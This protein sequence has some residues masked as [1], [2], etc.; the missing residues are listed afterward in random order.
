MRLA[1]SL[2][3]STVRLTTHFLALA[4]RQYDIRVFAL[5]W[6]F[7]L[8]IALLLLTAAL[9]ISLPLV[10]LLCTRR[11]QTAT[12]ILQIF[13]KE[14]IWRRLDDDFDNEDGERESLLSGS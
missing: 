12:D 9:A 1:A 8:V 3:V 6:I 7:A 11:Y 5:Q 13:G 2:H 10:R 14:L 4:V